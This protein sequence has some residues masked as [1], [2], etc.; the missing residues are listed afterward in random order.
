MIVAWSRSA[1]CFRLQEDNGRH[2]CQ[3]GLSRLPTG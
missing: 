3:I 1:L 2:V